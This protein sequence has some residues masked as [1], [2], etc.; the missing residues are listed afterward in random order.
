MT[1]PR[2]LVIAFL[3]MENA[4]ATEN[5]LLDL[6]SSDFRMRFRLSPSMVE[7]ILHDIRPYLLNQR[8]CGLQPHHRFLLALRYYATGD[9]CYSIGDCHNVSKSS[10][11]D[12]VASVTSA[13]NETYFSEVVSWPTESDE[14]TK[15]ASAFFLKKRFPGVCGAIDGT[16]IPILAPSQDEWQYV[17]RKGGHSLN[18]M[19]V[20]GPRYEFFALNCNWPGSVHDAR[21]LRESLMFRRFVEG[22]RPF[23]NAV[24]VGDSAYLCWTG[25]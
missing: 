20:A 10:V 3:A 22:W 18:L 23:P 7:E 5:I 8:E 17:D 16:L 19:A 4:E 13:L 1:A 15:V 12:A 2:S 14:R 6:T 25:S 9:F 21:V 24:L 11:H